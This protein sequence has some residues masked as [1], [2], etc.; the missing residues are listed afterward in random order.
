[1][2]I[3]GLETI[4]YCVDDLE[5]SFDFFEDFGLRPYDKD[6]D[7]TRFKLP[8]TS[9]VI[10]QP[11]D[12]FPIAGSKVAGIGVHE[13]IWGVD[14][15]DDLDRYVARLSMDRSVTR[16]ADGTVH[17]VAD[18]G[19]AMGLRLWPSYRMPTTSVDPINSPGNINRLNAHRKWIARAFPKRIMHVVYLVPDP[20]ACRAFLSDRLDFRVSDQQRGVGVYLRCDGTNDHH[21]IFFFNS[22]SPMAGFQGGTRFHHVNYVVTDLDEMMVGRN[23]MSRR[24]WEK[25]EW[26]L[27]RHRIGSAL[28]HYLPCP[29][30][31]EAEYGADGDQ[32]DDNWIPRDWDASFGFGHWLHDMPDFWSQGHNWDV[33]FLEGAAPNRGDIQPRSYNARGGDAKLADHRV[34]PPSSPVA[35]GALPDERR[36]VEDIMKVVGG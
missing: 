20:D 5:R 18:G 16:D 13:I 31:G 3:L 21:N 34:P 19:L 22:N 6:A 15:Q 35:E 32:L 30:G 28:F 1:M 12:R 26:G 36:T 9:N 4:V 14:T 8:D 2:A 24:G 27:G 33:G 11:H 7:R 25:S 23:Y 29:A 17:F 10:L